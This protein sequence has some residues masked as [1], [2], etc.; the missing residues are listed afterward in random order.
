MLELL[1]LASQ[2][3]RDEAAIKRL[4][5]IGRQQTP[6]LEICID[7]QPASL[8]PDIETQL[9]HLLVRAL[10]HVLD[11]LVLSGCESQLTIHSLEQIPAASVQPS[12]AVGQCATGESDYETGEEGG[13]DQHRA[14]LTLQRRSPRRWVA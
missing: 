2:T 5:L 12:V 11:L 9:V 3:W 1:G 6:Y 14:G 7:H 13:R 10:H 8:I 4:L